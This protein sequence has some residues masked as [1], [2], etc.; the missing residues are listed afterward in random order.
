MSKSQVNRSSSTTLY[1]AVGD[2]RSIDSNHSFG[3]RR[4]LTD[5]FDVHLTGSHSVELLT[6]HLS[7]ILAIQNHFCIYLRILI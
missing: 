7:L 3:L 6:D 5:G 1:S 4:S 2:N